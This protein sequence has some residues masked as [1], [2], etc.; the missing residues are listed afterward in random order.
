MPGA[1]TPTT[2]AGT[3][4]EGAGLGLTGISANLNNTEHGRISPAIKESA[5]TVL[6]AKAAEMFAHNEKGV[7]WF[8]GPPLDVVPLPRPHHS[9]E[10]LAK[11]QKMQNGKPNRTSLTNDDG[12]MT[13]TNNV[14]DAHELE[15][16]AEEALP[17]V[18]H[19][20]QAMASFML[21]TNN[22]TEGPVE[23]R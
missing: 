7:L 5:S 17:A 22:S 20:L 12:T 23:Q 6:S 19:G 2:V 9:V 1:A 16:P 14:N 18:L 4:L 3:P 10:Y 15:A 21:A 8:A 11:R 13:M